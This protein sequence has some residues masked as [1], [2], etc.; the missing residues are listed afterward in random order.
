[1]VTLIFC[2]F[3]CAP[4]ESPQAHFEFLREAFIGH[5][6]VQRVH[7]LMMGNHV[8]VASGYYRRC[9]SDHVRPDCGTEKQPDRT[10]EHFVRVL[11][12]DVTVSDTRD[13]GDRP[14]YGSEVFVSAIVRKVVARRLSVAFAAAEIAVSERVNPGVLCQALQARCHDPST[15]HPVRA[16][17]KHNK[18][19]DHSLDCMR[20]RVPGLKALINSGS[21]EDAN[22]LQKPHNPQ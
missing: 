12:C 21:S 4:E 20:Q 9:I 11:R 2:Y 16:N 18:Q 6:S 3:F 10:N 17:N 8:W 1:L 13:R 7:R 5:E 14:V 22:E 15:C 19:L